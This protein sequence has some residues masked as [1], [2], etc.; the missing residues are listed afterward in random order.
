MKKD[1][2]IYLVNHDK[3]IMTVIS[4][5]PPKCTKLTFVAKKDDGL[6]SILFQCTE[7]S[8]LRKNYL[9]LHTPKFFLLK[10]K[11]IIIDYDKLEFIIKDVE[12]D[13]IT[14]RT[15]F[16]VLRELQEIER[17]ES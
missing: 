9:M 10:Q 4:K 1:D 11:T 7:K 5:K 12:R 16:H 3:R 2:N 15:V 13:T 6:V 8:F 14:F 17:G